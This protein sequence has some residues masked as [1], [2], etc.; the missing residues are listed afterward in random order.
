MTE[1]IG[2]FLNE[3]KKLAGEHPDQAREALDKAEKLID[4]RTGGTHGAQLEQAEKF[5]DER[6]GL[7]EQQAQTPQ[8]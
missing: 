1:G 7:G 8:Q 3:A 2:G 5:A 4:E 6:L